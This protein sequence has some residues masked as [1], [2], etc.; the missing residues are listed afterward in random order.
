M[1]ARAVVA[2][3]LALAAAPAANAS[4]VPSGPTPLAGSTFQGGD[5]DQ[6]D[7]DRYV[8]WQ[9]LHAAGRVVHNADPNAQD[10]IFTGGSKVLEPGE[11]GLTT[12]SGGASP[13]KDNILD[14][15]SA[16]DQPAA[17]TFLYLGFARSDATG[18][19]AITFELNRDTRL[20]DNGRA[21]IPCRTTGDLLLSTLPHG[22]A[23]ELALFRWKTTQADAAT[24]C[25]RRGTVERMTDIPAGTA[26]GAVNPAQITS[27]LPGAYA[28]GS[29]ITP[30]A[31]SE[32][33]LDLGRLIDAAF[34]DSCLAFGSIWMHSRSSVSETS[35]LNDYVAPRRVSV[36][37]CSAS[38]TKFFDLD[39]DGV[40]DA[41]EPGLPRFLVWADYDDD[42][43]RDP[44]EP[45]SVTD[46]DGEYVIDDITRPYRLRETLA[47]SDRRRST[48][49][50]WTCS[51]PNA[52]TV[53]GFADG[54]GGIFA[55]GWGPIDPE[56]TPNAGGRD[57]GNWVP[58]TLTLEKQ[59]W[60]S[61]DPGRFDLIVNGV[62]A[63]AAAGDGDTITL[64]LRPG[65]YAVQE[66][67]V[68]GTDAALYTSTVT[69]R[70]VTTRRGVL[71]SGASWT[72]LRLRAGD[73]GLCT[74]VNA[75]A[76]APGIA[77]EK[78][79]PALAQAG[80]TLDYRFYVTNPGDL[81]LGASS[82]GVTDPRCDDPPRLTSKNGDRSPG[83]L[84]PEDTWTYACTH[85]T[86]PA[87]DEC[88]VRSVTNDATASGSTGEITVTDDASVTTTVECP[89]VPPEPPLPPDPPS[90]PAPQP[91]PAPVP[92]LPG[93]PLAP[94]PPFVPP[95]PDVPD[96][97][98]GG[99]AGIAASSARCIRRASEIRLTGQRMR[100][101]A[102]R[103]DGR[104][105]ALR[106]VRLLQRS[107]RPLNRIFAPGRHVL[108]VRVT[109]E[110][111]SATAPVTL[112]RTIV[113][114]GR[115]SQRPRV[116]G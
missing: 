99:I 22:N 18:T 7:T 94:L 11:W 77:I 73:H 42:G 52:S 20:W 105:I 82:V 88:E 103:V 27:R 17:K 44:D 111:G 95:G 79:G 70:A 19:A 9:G 91:A 74:F 8:D 109:F 107:V 61:D 101:L 116:T 13:G 4:I 41:G 69:C 63:V 57:F 65:T 1:A 114:C 84:D 60:P 5:G 115:A 54:P 97:G 62:T 49:I 53:G 10:T 104:R 96:A 37:T 106:T 102:V 56:A 68:A 45:F 36:R 112:R 90:P 81:P 59:L 55:C 85:A 25:A 51:F 72:G 23:I 16:V 34:G 76:G 100:V 2:A 33:A 30:F 29:P 14:A 86:A 24:G 71:R 28:P 48:P 64:A 66:S 43:V 32:S 92:P 46:E 75:R 113:V 15:W 3:I 110:E 98:A 58:A 39:A 89:D 26:Q 21:R 108:T 31:F 38:G 50:G 93:P 78:T 67:A 35:N 47:T 83:T 6:D 80:D 40:R 87:G 12:T